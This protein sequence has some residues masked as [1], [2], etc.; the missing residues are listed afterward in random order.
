MTKG[1]KI[2]LIVLGLMVVLGVRFL[3][4]ANSSKGGIVWIILVLA[5][6]AYARAILKYEKKSDNK[7]KLDQSSK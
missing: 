7:T 6:A 2:G 1:I 3:F 5:Y 4:M